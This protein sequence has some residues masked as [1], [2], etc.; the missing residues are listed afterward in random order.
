[1]LHSMISRRRHFYAPTAVLHSF[2]AVNVF[3]VGL[4]R[5]GEHS[6]GSFRVAPYGTAASID[7]RPMVLL[8]WVPRIFAGFLD[9]RRRALGVVSRFLTFSRSEG[10]YIV[11]GSTAGLLLT[12]T[13]GIYLAW[14]Q[15]ER[16]YKRD[17]LKLNRGR[18]TLH[19]GKNARLL[20]TPLLIFRYACSLAFFL[21]SNCFE[22][23]MS[24]CAFWSVHCCQ[25]LL[26]T[27]D[28]QNTF[29]VCV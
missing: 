2:K 18:V 21:S 23:A 9:L 10:V 17:I 12:I 28:V 6:I 19:G 5:A 7:N 24:T 11:L 25:D 26:L 16:D 15:Q 20:T 4:Y 13:L 14:K 1:M 29:Y 27:C 8:T 22:F 3:F